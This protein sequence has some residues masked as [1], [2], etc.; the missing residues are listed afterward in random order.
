MELSQYSVNEHGVLVLNSNVNR[1]SSISDYN[2]EYIITERNTMVVNMQY[3]V[4]TVGK[5]GFMHGKPVADMMGLDY[6][7]IG[8]CM[9][10]VKKVV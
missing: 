9:R 3:E 4:L 8:R 10:G 2:E 5:Y 1:L 6:I 7:R